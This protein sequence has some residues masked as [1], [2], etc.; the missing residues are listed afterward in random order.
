MDGNYK[1]IEPEFPEFEAYDK[2]GNK[3]K[4]AYAKIESDFPREETYDKNG[5]KLDEYLK[6][7]VQILKEKKYIIKIEIILY[8]FYPVKKCVNFIRWFK[9]RIIW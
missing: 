3:L 5:N 8:I 9:W 7:L 2:N 6:K 4:E 1:T